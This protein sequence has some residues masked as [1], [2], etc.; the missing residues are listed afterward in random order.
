MSAVAGIG[1]TSFGPAPGRTIVSMGVDAALQALQD[2]NIP[3]HRVQA[4]YFANALGARL[5]GD[6]TIGQNVCAALGLDRIT[7]VNVENACTSGSTALY[8][9]RLAIEAGEVDTALVIGAEKMCVPQLGLIDSGSTELDTQLGLVTPASFALRAVR[10]MHEFGTTAE[11][12]ACV[13]VKSRVHAALNTNAMFRKPTTIAEV[14]D[15]PMIADP[16]TRSQCCPTADGAA[17]VVLVSD[18]I[19]AS[20]PR[21]IRVRSLVLTSGDYEGPVDL[22]HWETDRLTAQLAYERASVGP[23]DVN[24]VECHDAFTISELLHCEGLGLCAPGEGGRFIA[25]GAAS[26]GGRVPVNVSGGLLSRGHPV[27]A[28]GL[29][30]IHELVTQLRGEAGARQVDGCRIGLAQCMGGDKAGDTKSCTV[31]I[32][33]T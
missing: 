5:F 30:Q 28:T 26:L 10:H 22:A 6:T 32:L 24:V 18:R 9:A 2:A 23:Q 19:A 12:L 13:T 3:K 21:A 14:L 20:L 25:S 27:A 7:V 17:A 4:T 11:Q 33:S 29:A 31:A 8:L 1:I 16:L 15:S